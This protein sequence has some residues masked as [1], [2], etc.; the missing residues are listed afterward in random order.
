MN[1]PYL[2]Q[3]NIFNSPIH[4][5]PIASQKE[6]QYQYSMFDNQLTNS[7]T[8]SIDLN[9]NIHNNINN[10]NAINLNSPQIQTTLNHGII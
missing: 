4:S 5:S 6:S 9:Q 2:T 8:T 7:T 1:I 3:N 10:N